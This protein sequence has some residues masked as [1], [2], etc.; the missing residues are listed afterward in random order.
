MALYQRAACVVAAVFGLASAAIG[1][2]FSNNTPISIPGFGTATPFPSTITVSGVT[3]PIGGFRIRLKNLSH[4]FPA[5]VKALLVAP[6]GS[7]YQ[8]LNGVGNSSI[9]GV[10]L[11]FAS[12]S[13]AALPNPMASGTYAATGCK[14]SPDCRIKSPVNRLPAQSCD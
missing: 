10:N 14:Y 9:T 7:A 5:D 6:N 1:Q 3:N 12:E 11:T 8:I 13:N 2:V 4:T